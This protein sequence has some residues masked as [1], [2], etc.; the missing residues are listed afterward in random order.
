MLLPNSALILGVAEVIRI[1]FRS[2]AAS[3]LRL[4]GFEIWQWPHF[5]QEEFFW[6]I[7]NNYLLVCNKPV[8]W[9]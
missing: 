3:Y 5:L 8:P 2:K 9:L 6:L 1:F 4:E 7:N